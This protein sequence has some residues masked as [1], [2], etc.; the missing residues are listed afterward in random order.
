MTAELTIL[1]ETEPAFKRFCLE[2]DISFQCVGEG[3]DG[4]TFRVEFQFISDIYALG[5]MV[6]L[7]SLHQYQTKQNKD[8]NN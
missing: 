8:L 2:L 1:K 6:A 3:I 5:K 7:E 4:D